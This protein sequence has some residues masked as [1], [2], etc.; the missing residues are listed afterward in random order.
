MTAKASIRN[1]YNL[2]VEDRV[3][4]AAVN[5]NAWLIEELAMRGHPCD[6]PNVSVS[7]AKSAYEL[8]CEQRVGLERVLKLSCQNL[9]R[10]WQA[11]GY[12]PLHSAARY[13]FTECVMALLAVGCDVNT[14]AVGAH[15]DQPFP[16]DAVHVAR[17]GRRPVPGWELPA[18]R[19]RP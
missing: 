2:P 16:M 6:V 4:W 15:R 8:L 10:G 1:V 17:C 9:W 7:Q 3:A 11:S 14:Q 13:D 12:T 19:R 5:N 18:L